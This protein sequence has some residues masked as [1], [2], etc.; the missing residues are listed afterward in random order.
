MS[1]IRREA[2]RAALNKSLAIVDYNV[3]DDMHKQHTF[4]EQ[5]LLADKSLTEDE[6]TEAIKELYEIY[7]RDK[8]ISNSGTNYLKANFSNWTSGNNDIDNLIQKC[9]LETIE[10]DGVIEWIPYNNLQNIKYL[11]KGSFSEI[12]TAVWIDGGYEEWNFKKQQLI[13]FGMQRV[14]LKRL[15]NVE[16]ANQRWF[17][18][19]KSHLT[20]SSEL[21]NVMIC[22]L[23]IYCIQNEIN[24]FILGDLGF[25]GPA[26]KPLESIYGNLPYIAPE[27]ITGKN[28][29]K[30]SDIYS[31]AM[32]MWEISS[33]QPPF[34][35]YENDY[36]LAK[37]IVNGIRPRIVSGTPLEYERLMK[38]CWDADPSNRP[39]TLTVF[40]KITNINYTSSRLFMCKIYQFDD[41]PEPRNATEVDDLSNQ[42]NND[43]SESFSKDF[44]KLQINS[45][46]DDDEILYN[47]PN[48]RSEEQD[49]IEIPDDGVFKYHVYLSL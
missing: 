29:T 31:I 35:D 6:K 17:E 7:D 28:T 5:T 13:R 45:K 36:Y 49:G 2:I 19:A 37:N 42:K 27:V 8:I 4:R 30:K 38:Q 46:D 21:P 14:I 15:E 48:L 18:E 41:F 26:D 22:I 40:D 3:C 34:G 25:C 12:Y 1:A 23:E 16:N 32:L 44:N 24:D 20:L 39:Y 33:G 9:Q 47:N 43:D 10:P 11:T